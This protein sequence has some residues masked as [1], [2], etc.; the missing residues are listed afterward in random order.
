THRGLANHVEWA[1]RELAS[2]GS[3]GAPVFSSV[4]FDLVVPNVWAPLV[5]GQ[6]VWLYG[7]ELTELG[8]ALVAA[9]PFSFI[10]LT[11]GHLEVLD[12]QLSDERV[13]ELTRKV[14]VAGEALPGQLVERWR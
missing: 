13:Q 10:K 5:A 7:G 3:G 1:E 8:D 14:V 4:A 12:G 11:P 6:R 9:G 2:S